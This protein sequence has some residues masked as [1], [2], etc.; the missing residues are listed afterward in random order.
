M[1]VLPKGISLE[2]LRTLCLV[3]RSGSIAAAAVNDLTRQSQFSRQVKELE[4]ALGKQLLK[5]EG[6]SVKPTEA[7]NQLAMLSASFFSGLDG[8]CKPEQIERISVAAGDAVLRNIIL[9]NV[10]RLPKQDFQWQFRSL[11]TKPALDGLASSEIDLAVV[12]SDAVGEGHTTREFAQLEYT[13]VFPRALL[14]GRTAAGIFNASRL[15]FA[16]L[17][18]D[19]KLARQLLEIAANNHLNLVVQLELESFSLIHD[20]VMS[21]EVG[22]LLPKAVAGRLPGDRF[23]VI[24]D[25]DLAIP[26]RPLS[27]VALTRSYDVRPQLR[28]AFDGLWRTCRPG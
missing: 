5:K 6:R 2:R 18:G 23:A 8:L 13:W 25:K 27:L 15:P 26:S 9:P 12:R 10:K 4:E 17:S 19:G 7:G 22:A 24:E 11:R 14:P 16:M 1:D 21:E 3:V 28:A 20:A